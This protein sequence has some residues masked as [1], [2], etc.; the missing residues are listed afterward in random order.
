MT[1]HNKTARTV[2]ILFLVSYLGFGIGTWMLHTLT[3]ASDFPFNIEADRLSLIAGVLIESLNEIAI[4]GI[5]VMLFP[6]LKKYGEG[7]ALGYVAFRVLE[8]LMYWIGHAGLLS[9]IS[10]S[11]GQHMGSADAATFE[12]AAMLMDAQ[13][14]WSAEMATLPFIVGALILYAILY[15]S[16][17]VPRTL[18]ILGLVGVGGLVVGNVLAQF[19]IGHNA[20]YMMVLFVPIMASEIILALWLI[21]KGF[22]ADARDP[23]TQPHSESSMLRPA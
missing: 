12:S 21:V 18:S 5:S 15:R 14:N 4:V 19:G 23:L 2:G 6:I 22:S 1:Q 9:L 10:L 13:R 16:A 7:L 17:L 8:A 11:D 20:W 3:S